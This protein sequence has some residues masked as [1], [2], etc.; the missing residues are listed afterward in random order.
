MIQDILEKINRCN[1]PAYVKY[2][3]Y[4]QSDNKKIFFTNFFIF[5]DAETDE[6]IKVTLP[7]YVN[8]NAEINKIQDSKKKKE[9][10]QLVE[11]EYILAISKSKLWKDILT[12]NSK[13]NIALYPIKKGDVYYI[14]TLPEFSEY[15]DDTKTKTKKKSAKTKNVRNDKVKEK[16]I[17]DMLLQYPFNVFNFKT[18]E[19][20]ESR[21]TSKPYYISKKDMID[22][23][24]ANQDLLKAFPKGYKQLK[25]EELCKVVFNEK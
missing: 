14:K 25:K 18:R 9:R 23:I 13:A 4:L 21:Q 10:K 19:E 5:E 8:V 1:D 11:L 20:C 7:S 16:V 2:L 12:L 22:K 6:K 17:S 15:K 3:K 24:S